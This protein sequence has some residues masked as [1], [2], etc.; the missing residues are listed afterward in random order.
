MKTVCICTGP[1]PGP[2]VIFGPGPGPCVISGPGLGSGPGSDVVLLR[3]NK[4]E[5]LLLR[6]HLHQVA[7]FSAL[8][9]GSAGSLLSIWSCCWDL[10]TNST[11]GL[12]SWCFSSL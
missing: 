1:G 10:K 3:V 4:C 11:M 2:C 9:R 8:P 5:W 12:W 7:A 6:G